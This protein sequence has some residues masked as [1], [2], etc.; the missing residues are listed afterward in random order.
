MNKLRVRGQRLPN[1]AQYCYSSKFYRSYRIAG[2][3]QRIPGV[4]PKND[5]DL[6]SLVKHSVSNVSG[7]TTYLE[8][9]LTGCF[10]VI[11]YMQEPS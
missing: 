9:Y 8:N 11:R 1:S 7:T 2:A 3:T 5:A 10:G 4:F 6:K